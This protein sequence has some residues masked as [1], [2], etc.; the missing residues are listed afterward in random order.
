MKP[1]INTDLIYDLARLARKY[2]PEDW[3][4]L[5][6]LL[7]DDNSRRQVVNLLQEIRAVSSTSRKRSLK[8]RKATRIPD[9]LK[10]VRS[11]DP[12]KGIILSEFWKRLRNHEL[13]V[14]V[15]NIRMFAN[16]VGLQ[17]ITSTKRD[18]AIGELMRQMIDLP[19][20]KVE[21]ALK[22]ATAEP[23]N[24]GEEYERWVSLILGHK[25]GPE[26]G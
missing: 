5:L 25:R 19:R 26:E 6:R 12:E 9:L 24:F 11:K 1:N 3:D 15:S 17:D 20:E 7:N 18:Q 13:L 8:S 2:T 21:D 4:D 14:K 10:D 23:R 16:T 22:K